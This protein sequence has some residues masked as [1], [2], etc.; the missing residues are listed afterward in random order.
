MLE[1][2]FSLALHET[3]SFD[4]WVDE[5]F[6]RRMLIGL[7]LV[8]FFHSQECG[9][10]RTAAVGVILRRDLSYTGVDGVES[11]VHQVRD[12]CRLIGDEG[13]Q[14]VLVEVLSAPFRSVFTGVTANTTPSANETR[15][16]NKCLLKDGK[17]P[18]TLDSTEIIH[19]G[20]G[21]LHGSSTL[22]VLVF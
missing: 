12:G 3:A 10:G 13:I 21:I 11:L 20:M 1:F 6:T 2:L 4:V 17:V 14:Q 5:S 19:K 8:G 16:D 9:H 15:A 18:L 22:S 7:S